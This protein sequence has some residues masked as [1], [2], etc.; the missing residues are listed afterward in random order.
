MSFTAAR[1][2]ST[3]AKLADTRQFL[4]GDGAASSS[5]SNGITTATGP[6]ISSR[7]TRMPLSTPVKHGGPQVVPAASAARP[8]AR[9]RRSSARPR[10]GRARRSRRTL[11]RWSA[12]T[13][14]PTSVASRV[15]RR[16]A[17]RR[18]AATSRSVNSSQ[19]DALHEDAAAGQADLAGVVEDAGDARRPR[20]ASRSASAKTTF[21][22]LPPSSKLTGVRRRRDRGHDRPARARLAGERDA[23]D[24]AGGA[25]SASPAPS[26]PNPCTTFSTPG[27]R[28]A[29]SA[30]SPS[31]VAVSGVCSAGLS[32][33]VQPNASAGAT[34]HVACMSGKFQGLMQAATPAGS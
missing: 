29:S 31:R 19:I 9:R 28:P 14:G 33:A 22:D 30:S 25:V 3:V 34:F 8:A 7:A 11:S 16:P 27:G 1:T 5:S 17:A 12:S 15:G 20:R 24:V 6:K 2:S 32:T 10:R 23:V 18:A 13:S 26:G 21:A 4:R